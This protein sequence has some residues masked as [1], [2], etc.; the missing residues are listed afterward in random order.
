MTGILLKNSYRHLLDIFTNNFS[1]KLDKSRIFIYNRG[2]AFN[3]KN[4]LNFYIL[5]FFAASSLFVGSTTLN[6][7]EVDDTFIVVKS[8]DEADLS[9]DRKE[10]DFLSVRFDKIATVAK[11]LIGTKYKMGGSSPKTGFDCSGF[12]GYVFNEGA[13]IK[14]PRS[15][16]EMRGIGSPV[17]IKSLKPG[18]LIFFRLNSS[19]VGIYIGDNKF[20][21]A[22]STGRSVAID[23]LMGS[24]FQK[25]VVGA[26]RIISE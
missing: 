1:K 2:M 15:S 14:L 8:K 16:R 7:A 19:H 12:V 11:E 26:R 24:F 4:L 22:P 18:D 20:I 13:G 3:K 9:A 5:S 17:D 6:A 10:N 21:H 25:R 23:S